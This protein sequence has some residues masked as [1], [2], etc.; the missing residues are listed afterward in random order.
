MR[1]IILDIVN[2]FQFCVGKS[3]N[4]VQ[5]KVDNNRVSTMAYPMKFVIC[6]KD[7]NKHE[8]KIFACYDSMNECIEYL[9]KKGR[10]VTKNDAFGIKTYEI[11]KEDQEISMF[12]VTFQH[13]ELFKQLYA[14]DGSNPHCTHKGAIHISCI[15]TH[16]DFS[17]VY[18][19][20]SETYV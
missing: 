2:N 13:V 14:M 7:C 3:E 19:W 5:I 15:D 9:N 12:N 18:E 8:S 16:D 20:L 1:K 4:Y 17:D 11:S 10:K 6:G